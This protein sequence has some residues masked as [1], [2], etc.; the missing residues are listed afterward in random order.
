VFRHDV[1]E[2]YG[3][4]WL[5][6]GPGRQQVM[7]KLLAMANE[8]DAYRREIAGYA[9]KEIYRTQPA[10]VDRAVLTRFAV[11][12]TVSDRMVAGELMLSLA[13]KGAD[14][15]GWIDS[16]EFWD[17]Y[18]P[19][20]RDDIND[21]LVVQRGPD[22][23]ERPGD[24][25]SLLACL[26]V[27]RYAD[28]LRRRLAEAPFFRDP[29]HRELALLLGGLKQQLESIDTLEEHATALGRAL[30]EGAGDLVDDFIRLLMC[31]PLWNVI[32]AASSLVATLV[33]RNPARKGLIDRLLGTDPA[34]WRVRYG[35]V[36][37][38]YN[39]G[40][41]DGYAK[42]REVLL[43]S[44][45]HPHGRVRGLCADDLL[46]WL[47]IGDTAQ[48]ERIVGD[49]EIQRVI[50]TWVAQADDSWLL[51]YVYLIV[52]YVRECIEAGELTFDLARL[53]PQQISRYLGDADFHRL[54]HRQALER[55]EA[56]RRGE[57]RSDSA[58]A[59]GL[60]PTA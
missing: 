11:S 30:D 13:I 29:E 3:S 56:C 52:R 24:D 26:Q 42:F 5:H 40:E 58:G 60:K 53:I 9:L 36:D 54:T 21:T 17:P 27:H 44:A 14:T 35:V 22:P 39:I 19:Y 15:S 28:A 12:P 50:R 33:T 2:A 6:A 46:G 1:G 16:P 47:R 48:R 4:T 41:V 18:W 49:P 20:L 10:V 25:D 7:D 23:G 32:E 8:G 51:E 31:H 38:S 57:R 34:Q 43:A 37:S 59:T 55:I 45:D